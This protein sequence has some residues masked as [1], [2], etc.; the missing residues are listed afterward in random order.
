MFSFNKTS[1][2][3]DRKEKSEQQRILAD[4]Y[5]KGKSTQEKFLSRKSELSQ[6]RSLLLK[7]KFQEAD[8]ARRKKEREKMALLQDIAYYGLWQSE[9]QVQR[10]LT[11][12]TTKG[13]RLNAI[14]V[15][16]NF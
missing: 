4:S 6:Q 14:K 7:Q 5:R 15:Q 11:T 3:L 8:K 16:L 12:Y 10:N 2:W 9:D 1:E 13:E